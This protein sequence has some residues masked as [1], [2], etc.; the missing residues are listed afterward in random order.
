MKS[1]YG[2]TDTKEKLNPTEHDKSNLKVRNFLCGY[3]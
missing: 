2:K 3:C 1:K